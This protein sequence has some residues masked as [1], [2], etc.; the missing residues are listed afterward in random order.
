MRA[1]V[2][3]LYMLCVNLLGLGIG[4]TMVAL[5]IDYVFKDSILVGHSLAATA[6]ITAPVSALIIYTGL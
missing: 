4:P 3:A 1:Q 2:S 5:M 6:L